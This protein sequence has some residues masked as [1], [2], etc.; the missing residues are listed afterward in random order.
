MKGVERREIPEGDTAYSKALR[1][2][3]HTDNLEV[4][5][6]LRNLKTD[7]GPKTVHSR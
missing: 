7:P 1:S 4:I 2:D 5:A 6:W 3:S